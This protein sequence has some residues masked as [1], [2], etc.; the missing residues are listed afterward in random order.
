MGMGMG[1]SV[2]LGVMNVD[3]GKAHDDTS[4][5]EHLRHIIL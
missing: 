4:F 1:M 3:G 2:I 5:G